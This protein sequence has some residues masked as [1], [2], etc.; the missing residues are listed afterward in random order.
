MVLTHFFS[1]SLGELQGVCIARSFIV[2][3][4]SFLEETTDPA[5]KL[6][7]PVMNNSVGTSLPPFGVVSVLGFG[8]FNSYGVVS[9]CLNLQFS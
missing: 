2:R 6:V 8:N 5:C 7:V 4:C 3:Q 9:Y 1:S